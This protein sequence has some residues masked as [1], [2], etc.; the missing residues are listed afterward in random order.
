[1]EITTLIPAYKPKYL[2]DLL[3]SFRN[4]TVKPAQIFI[5]DDSPDR[6]FIKMLNSE[7]LKDLI[8]DLN[9]TSFQG[10]Q[11]G[12]YNNIRH[13]MHLY[14]KS[15]KY[16][17][18]LNDDDFLYPNFYERHSA[19]HKDNNFSSVISRRWTSNESG[20]PLRDL[21][22]PDEINSNLNRVITIDSDYLFQRTAALSMNW[23]GEFSNTTYQSFMIDEMD[24]PSLQG[25]C[26]SGL[27][28]LGSFLK[29]SL[30]T[31]VGYI[32]EHL[33][34][35]RLSPDQHS[36]QTMGTPMKWAFL[37]YL[38]LAISGNNIGKL[39]NDQCGLVLNNVIPLILYHFGSQQD[40]TEILSLLPS[41]Q[42][43]S[44]LDKANFLKSWHDYCGWSTRPSIEN[45]LSSVEMLS[46]I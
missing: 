2:I 23:L 31:P 43:N 44:D 42:N 19:V 14:N 33:G 35:F 27:E 37:A 36:A 8:K 21:P 26:F 15:T 1:M 20:V 29:S 4:Q 18:I 41:L 11:L 28:D 46:N 12:A 40:L 9:I 3:Q 45:I 7:P 38:G 13:L 39:S 25:V 22:V 34:Y 6:S 5:S 32:N 16:F 24:N 30:H 10:P 17:H